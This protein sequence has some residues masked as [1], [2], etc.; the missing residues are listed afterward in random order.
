MFTLIPG[1][2]CEGTAFGSVCLYTS[3]YTRNPK[4][5]SP[6]DFIFLHLKEF[7]HD[8]VLC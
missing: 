8:S 7:T 3:Y 5:I 1:G 4:P 6:I 2:E